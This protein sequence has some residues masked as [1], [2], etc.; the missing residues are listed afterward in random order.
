MLQVDRAANV[1]MMQQQH[2]REQQA[3]YARIVDA[4]ACAANPS[5]AQLAAMAAA[6][7][8]F[9][10]SH[11]GCDPL[12]QSLLGSVRFLATFLF[13]IL[14]REWQNIVDFV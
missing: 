10:T 9:Y 5:D 7:H 3:Q 11:Q 8:H 12:V 14:F 1:A 13:N 4:A 6:Q 2:L